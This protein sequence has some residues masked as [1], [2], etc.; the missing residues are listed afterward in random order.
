[1]PAAAGV[2]E[3]VPPLLSEPLSKLV[4]SSDVTV[5]VT[6]SLFFQVTFV[7]TFTVNV[8]GVKVIP[9]MFTVLG[10]VVVPPP[11]VVEVL[12][13]LPQPQLTTAKKAMKATNEAIFFSFIKTF[14]D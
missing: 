9:L 12:F 13:D 1:M 11:V 6:P 3:K 4:P 10:G 8:D 5:W 14:Y 2:K 7:P